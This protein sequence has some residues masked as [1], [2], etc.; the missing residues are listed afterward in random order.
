MCN[1]HTVCTY[2]YISLEHSQSVSACTCHGSRAGCCHQQ[3]H[4]KQKRA[5]MLDSLQDV[6]PGMDIISLQRIMAASIL[7]FI[8]LF[9]TNSLKRSKFYS[10]LIWKLITHNIKEYI[11][12]AIQR[13]WFARVNALCN[14]SRKKS[15]EVAAHFRADFWVGVASRCV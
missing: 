4:C 3:N 8:T 1:K 6:A 13:S 12:W 15:W 10:F 5:F 11:Y 7:H 9:C 14:L 2:W